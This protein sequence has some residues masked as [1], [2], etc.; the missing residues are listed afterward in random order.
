MYFVFI[1]NYFLCYIIHIKTIQEKMLLSSD[2]L[3][4]NAMISCKIILSSFITLLFGT[5]GT[6]HANHFRPR[7]C[8]TDVM[9][10]I[11]NF[12]VDLLPQIQSLLLCQILMNTK[13]AYTHTFLLHQSYTNNFL[14][15]S[16]HVLLNGLKSF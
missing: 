9:T 3:N 14:N 15:N 5:H 8:Q 4:V 12:M 7:W 6:I 2:H 1:L 10:E 16:L 11:C 13:H